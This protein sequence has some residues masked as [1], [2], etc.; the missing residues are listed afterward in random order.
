[1]TYKQ[2]V[3]C[4]VVFSCVAGVNS[5][6]YCPLI[7]NAAEY[8]VMVM[9]PV[10]PPVAGCAVERY[11]QIDLWL[12]TPKDGGDRGHCGSNGKIRDGVL[13]YGKIRGD[14]IWK[15]KGGKTLTMSTLHIK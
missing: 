12:K 3:T 9:G 14:F 13:V 15:G 10:W 4:P 6:D 8:N 11:G 2:N 5:R 1:M 7:L